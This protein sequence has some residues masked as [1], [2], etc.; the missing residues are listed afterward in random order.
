MQVYEFQR[1]IYLAAP[2]RIK[3]LVPFIAAMRRNT[4]IAH[5]EKE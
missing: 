5:M 2:E 4:W 3:I 1:H